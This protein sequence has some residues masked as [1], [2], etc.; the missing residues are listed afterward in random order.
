MPR[1]RIGDIKMYYEIHGKGF[2]LVMITGLSA[3]KDW[4]PDYFIQQ[5]SKRFKLLLFDNRGA[6]RTD[7]PKIDYTIRM[8]ADDTIGLMDALEIEEAHMIGVSMGGMIAQELAIS[9]PDRVKKL[10]LCSTTPGGQKSIPTPPETVQKIMQ[11]EGLTDEQIARR[12][13][14]LLFTE[15]FI[16]NNP[17]VV[18]K[19]VNRMLIAPISRDAFMRQIK[20]IMQ[21]DAYDRLP[22]I[23]KPTLVMAG[24]ED[25]LIPYQNS[26]IL[27]QR[28]PR[29]KLVLYDKVGHGMITQVAEDCA[30]KILEFLEK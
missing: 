8:F 3:N 23:N 10:V 1:I 19:T 5:F 18:E 27:A 29:A 21:F 2:P 25:V 7:A 12:T 15:E 24:K 9:Y 20:A 30:K 13:I 22:K 14:P 11:S 17:D 6:G 28:I 26:E 4:W 16:K